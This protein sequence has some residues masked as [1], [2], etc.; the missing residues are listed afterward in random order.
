MALAL[1]GSEVGAVMNGE[2]I[3]NLRFADDIA[4]LAEKQ[5]D[6]QD[7]VSNIYRVGNSWD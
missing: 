3:G 6:L 2:I 1:E 5:G 7:S 4:T